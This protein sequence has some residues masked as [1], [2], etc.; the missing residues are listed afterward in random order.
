MRKVAK[1]NVKEKIKKFLQKILLSIGVSAFVCLV[2]FSVHAFRTGLVEKKVKEVNVFWW[3]SLQKIGFDLPVKNSV[4]VAGR[5][6]TEKD[7]VKKIINKAANAVNYQILRLDLEQIQNEL[8]SLPWVKQAD[9]I[10]Q[11]PD[12]LFVVLKERKPIALF[13]NKNDF[14]PIDEN[15]TL[16]KQKDEENVEE[17]III[18]GSGSVEKTPE[19]IKALNDFPKINKRVMGA[20]YIGNRR[21][22]LYIDD[23]LNG[24]VVDLPD[25]PLSES[26]KRLDEENTNKGILDKQVKRIDLRLNDRIITEPMNADSVLKPLKTAKGTKQ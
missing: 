20:K 26:L 16:V 8:K 4:L 10:R 21:W 22:Q 2:L 9:V 7:A 25:A 15:G 5:E 18:V 12:F 3:D 19:L 14:Y 11:L 17:L 24:I 13:K 1:T 6:R 23:L